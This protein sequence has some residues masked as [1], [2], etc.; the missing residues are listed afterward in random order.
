MTRVLRPRR[1]TEK[2]KRVE[3]KICSCSSK[4]KTNKQ[5]KSDDCC[6]NK[7]YDKYARSQFAWKFDCVHFET[8][9]PS[10]KCTELWNVYNA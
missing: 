2:I 8:N 5:T 10:T 1:A 3:W 7:V 4:D 9:R 6:R